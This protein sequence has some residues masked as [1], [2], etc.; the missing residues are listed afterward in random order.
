MTVI[1]NTNGTQGPASPL[2]FPFS[3]WQQSKQANYKEC[4]C[5]SQIVII[6]AV[7]R[8][9]GNLLCPTWMGQPQAK[10]GWISNVQARAFPGPAAFV[11]CPT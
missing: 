2:D 11:Q 8:P 1:I 6:R 3:L 7:K 5:D 10:H 4:C 9:G